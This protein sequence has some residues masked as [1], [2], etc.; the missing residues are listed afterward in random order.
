MNMS[1][2][3][4]VKFVISCESSNFNSFF[5]FNLR[6]YSLENLGSRLTLI[7]NQFDFLNSVEI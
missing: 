5:Y 3:E 1:K 2:V 4:I 6:E 7:F